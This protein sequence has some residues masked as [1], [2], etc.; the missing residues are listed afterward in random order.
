M[1]D[2]RTNISL[3]DGYIGLM[4]N[5]STDDKLDLIS[6]LTASV[7]KDLIRKRSSFKKAYGA[8]DSSKSAEQIIDEIRGSRISNRQIESF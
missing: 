8:F 2:V 3:V 5:L 6:R 4:R 7:K 1:S